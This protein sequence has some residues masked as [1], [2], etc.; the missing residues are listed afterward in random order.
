M[1]SRKS[2]YHDLI[3]IE[4]NLIEKEIRETI[5]DQSKEDRVMFLIGCLSTRIVDRLIIAQNHIPKESCSD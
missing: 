2:I 1:K 3:R 5:N 4:R